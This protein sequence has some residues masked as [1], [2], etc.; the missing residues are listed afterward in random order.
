MIKRNDNRGS[1]I[2]M[3]ILVAA[4]I[5]VMAAIALWVSLRNVQ[6]KTTDAEIKES[7]Y[8]AEG[9][10]EQVKAGVKE[11]A[12]AAG[13]IEL[14]KANLEQN[15]IKKLELNQKILRNKETNDGLKTQYDSATK[16]I[17][18]LTDGLSKLEAVEA[19]AKELI[20]KLTVDRSKMAMAMP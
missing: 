18:E 2:L 6:M 10:L 4:G 13:Q 15:K 9:V 1:S 14:Y 12:E 17:N 20:E 3:V 11:K 5:G 16:K 19:D 8:S 7:F